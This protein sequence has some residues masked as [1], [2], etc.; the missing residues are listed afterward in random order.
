MQGNGE[1]HCSDAA[2]VPLPAVHKRCLGLLTLRD[3]R[4]P[5]RP[6]A[7]RPQR[8]CGPAN[9]SPRSRRAFGLSTKPA[10]SL[11]EPITKGVNDE[12]PHG[13]S[14]GSPLP[15]PV[16]GGVYTSHLRSRLRNLPAPAACPRWGSVTLFHASGPSSQPHFGSEST[17]AHFSRTKIAPLCDPFAA[18]LRSL[19]GL[20]ILHPCQRTPSS[21]LT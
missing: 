6:P 20:G 21:S 9:A 14:R 8:P 18:L 5:R 11:C 19:F 13:L 2:K 15:V 16:G 17:F 1:E 12:A 3:S 10:R 4:R 7:R